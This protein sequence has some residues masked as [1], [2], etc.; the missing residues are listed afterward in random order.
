MPW[1]PMRR[2]LKKVMAVMALLT[3][4]MFSSSPQYHRWAIYY[5]ATLPAS[6]FRELDLV[7][8]DRRH[9]PD[10]A[11]LKGKLPVL[12]YVSMGEVYDDVPEKLALLK[13]DALLY[14]N[15]RWGSHAVDL[16]SKTWQKQL[17]VYVADAEA[18]GFDGIMLDTLDSPLFWAGQQSPE[19]L[20]VMEQEAISLIKTIRKEHPKLK[21]MVNRAFSILPSIAGEIDFVL[22]ESLLGQTSDSTGHSFTFSSESSL[23]LVR[24]LQALQ[25]HSP[26]LRIFTID[27]WKTDDIKGLETIYGLQRSYGFI[28]YVTTSELRDYT[29]EPG[30]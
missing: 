19:R 24:K 21:I 29:P 3:G 25:E 12:A 23:Q 27:Y 6:T 18:Q 8:F 20:A 1:W 13:D 14:R 15:V 26:H 4:C 28:P 2:Q 7:V 16:A 17:L 5:G 10:F 9:H 11:E 30:R 22:A